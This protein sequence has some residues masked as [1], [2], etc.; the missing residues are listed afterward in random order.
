[1]AVA[2]IESAASRHLEAVYAEMPLKGDLSDAIVL[3][4]ATVRYQ[5]IERLKR[6]GTT[7]ARKSNDINPYIERKQLR[8]ADAEVN[9][10][11]YRLQEAMGLKQQLEGKLSEISKSIQ[12]LSPEP[13]RSSPRLDLR[14]KEVRHQYYTEESSRRRT[15]WEITQKLRKERLEV[16]QRIQT[17]QREERERDSETARQAELQKAADCQ[18]RSEAKAKFTEEIKSLIAQRKAAISAQRNLEV[19]EQRRISSLSYARE[20]ILLDY[21][22]RI[23]VPGEKQ[24]ADI[25][26]K[27]KALHRPIE[28]QDLRAHMRKHDEEMRQMRLLREGKTL[29]LQDV[30]TTRSSAFTQSILRQAHQQHKER[31]S[32]EARKRQML[33]KRKRYGELVNTLFVPTLSPLKQKELEVIRAKLRPGAKPRFRSITPTPFRPRKF[34]PNPLVAAPRERRTPSPLDYL[35]EQRRLRLVYESDILPADRPKVT[36][37]W[38]KELS[39]DLTP[40]RLAQKIQEKS[41]RVDREFQRKALLLSHVHPANPQALVLGEQLDDSMLQSIRAKLSLLNLT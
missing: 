29:K 27:N 35:A 24:R 2:M 10:R 39:R 18:K 16:L 13:Q 12:R 41:L 5:V 4:L 37:D 25:L 21:H 23:L 11:K 34:K 31:E 30:A 40:S 28:M 8:Q 38:A 14:S 17:R 15:A 9:L 6:F 22:R 32:K 33:E 1:M 19:S 3:S 20:K 7:V 26:A 36:V